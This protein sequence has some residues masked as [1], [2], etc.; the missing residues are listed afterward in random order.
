[1]KWAGIN[2]S[3][4]KLSVFG[5]ST[6]TGTCSQSRVVGVMCMTGPSPMHTIWTD[7]TTQTQSTVCKRQT[8]TE[9]R[10]TSRSATQ[11]NECWSH[12][13]ISNWLY[14]CTK[15]IKQMVNNVPWF[16]FRYR[17]YINHL[18]T[19]L[20]TYNSSHKRSTKYQFRY[21]WN[22]Y[23][24]TH[25]VCPAS[26]SRFHSSSFLALSAISQ[27]NLGKPASIHWFFSNC[28]ATKQ[29]EKNQWMEAGLPR[30]TW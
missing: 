26:D 14:S 5:T 9:N 17:R 2:D 4:D 15:T 30:F 12:Q 19:Y 8:K 6:S 23:P 29:L 25:R 22:K 20:L 11:S 10:N 16:F 13:T 18:L 21:I 27:V 24:M 7:C 3:F 1:V 28:S